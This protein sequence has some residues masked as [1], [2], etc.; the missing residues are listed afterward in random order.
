MGEADG[1]L[2]RGLLAATDNYAPRLADSGDVQLVV[3][4]SVFEPA[5]DDPLLVAGGLSWLSDV[6]VLA[7]EYLGDP[8]ELRTLSP[9]ELDRRLRQIRLRRCSSFAL[10]VADQVI[11]VSGHE[12]VQAVSHARIPTLLVNSG[13]PVDINLLLEA[14]P[15][16]TKLVG[17]RRNTLETM[18]GR[19]ARDGFAGGALGPTEEKLA[20]AIRRDVGVV[21]DHFAATRGGVERRLAALLP[22]I[23]FLKGREAADRLSD[24]HA[25]LG[26][27]L[28]LR[29]W[30][31][32][33]FDGDFVDRILAVV[34]ET[35]DQRTIRGRLGF[36]FAAYGRALAELGYPPL[37]DEADFRRLVAVFL[38]EIRPSLLDRL[39][40]RFAP[41]WRTGGDL[42][43]YVE[44]RRLDFIA[45]DSS[46]PLEREDI[47][48]AFVSSQALA[49]MDT[50]LGPDDLSVSLQPLDVVTAANRK[51]LVS[52][53][54]RLSSVIRAW[55]RKS[56]IPRPALTESVDPQPLV[57]ALDQTGLIDFEM[58][59][60]GDLP[61][62][63]RRVNAWPVGMPQADALDELGLTDADLQH[64]EREARDARRKAEIARRTI[65]FAGKP[66]DTGSADFAIIF[67]QLADTA[68]AKGS[69][70]F[71]RS[72]PPRLTLQEQS[73]EERR[74]TGTRSGKGGE[75]RNQPPDAVLKAMGVASEWLAREYLRRRHPREMTD[76]CWVSSNREAFCTGQ[77]GDDSLGYD[78]RVETARHEYL[79]EVK[80]AIDEGGEF[81][82]TARELEVAGSASLDRKRRY[83]IL[84]V[85]YVFDPKR[86]R[87]LPLLN[88]VGSETRNRFRVVRSGSVRY[89]F[90]VR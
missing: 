46:W 22:V 61:A 27:A 75:W 8:L 73:G 20:H 1:T 16:L 33:E 18:L 90:E 79:Y 10:T 37:N 84:Y 71:S 66:L 26:P 76:A 2:I 41:V 47:D 55:C 49:A 58:L 28:R 70:W 14:S 68:L 40:R 54:A 72:R 83:R 77:P 35:E 50:R 88:P 48:L 65:E 87:V 44:L 29:E 52:R 13:D 82:L 80:S 74:R 15:A 86:W 38:A 85:P 53:Y 67:E 57:R 43:Q 59:K 21:R 56:D 45:F 32:S 25:R 30:L 34:D 51:L 24:R 6:A 64:E 63:L 4:G 81:E 23:A 11:S 7:H 3:D 39:R 19:L 60:A 31:L 78:F 36:D 62:F 9:E 5:P 89:R 69:E 12:R 17:S 42:T